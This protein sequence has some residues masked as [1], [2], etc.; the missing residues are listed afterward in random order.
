MRMNW[1]NISITFLLA[2][3]LIF[4]VNNFANAKTLGLYSQ[5]DDAGDTLANQL[6]DRHLA[7]FSSFRDF[8]KNCRGEL[9]ALDTKAI[10]RG[11]LEASQRGNISELTAIIG[12]TDNFSN[13]K[14]C[15]DATYDD[16]KKRALREQSAYEE[17]ASIGIYSDGDTK[18]SDFDLITD[19]EKINA[20]IFSN[21]ARYDGTINNS[22]KSLSDFLKGKNPEKINTSE[23]ESINKNTITSEENWQNTSENANITNTINNTIKTSVPWDTVCT[24]DGEKY[25]SVNNM[26]TDDF[27]AELNS[28]L[29]GNTKT[30]VWQD[31]SENF[32][33]KNTQSNENSERNTNENTGS[34]KKDFASKLPCNDIFCI[35]IG[36]NIGSQNL[37]TGGKWGNSIEDIL[38]KH[39]EKTEDISWSDLSAQKMTNNSFQLPFLNTKFANKVA[40]GGVF[41][42]NSPQITKTDTTT[43]EKKEATFDEMYRCALINAD[44]DTDESKNSS[45]IG[46]SFTR[47]ESNNSENIDN[48]RIPIDPQNTSKISGNNNCKSILRELHRQKQYESF[49]TEV[50]EIAAFTRSMLDII[51]QNID[52][53]KVLDSKPIQ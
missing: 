44:L 29:A 41:I 1:K 21:P 24:P 12:D 38:N 8:W 19:I 4:G 42:H 11:L 13:I 33:K 30:T 51:N 45:I 50:N 53:E 39:I 27:I 36:S 14:N 52:T 16:I 34:E 32:Y 40:G 18:N 48:G 3:C 15:L 5:V 25:A 46:A 9:P 22:T 49:S 26:V 35:T 6:I 43:E 47:R 28:T 17:T 37:L 20:I 7:D 23:T 31:Y 2:N 10:D